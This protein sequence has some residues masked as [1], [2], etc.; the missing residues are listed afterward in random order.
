M[1]LIIHPYECIEIPGKGMIRFGMSSEE[2]K[3]FFQSPPKVFV[4]FQEFEEPSNHFKEH[5]L[6]VHYKKNGCHD[7]EIFGGYGD[8]VPVFQDKCLFQSPYVELREWF[9]ALDPNLLI[10]DDETNFVSLT[11]GICICRS[12]DIDESVESEQI[13]SDYIAVFDKKSQLYASLFSSK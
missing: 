3:D 4:K 6:Q 13:C 9:Q 1:E 8:A 12:D 7:F 10:D 5:G 2:V 11:F